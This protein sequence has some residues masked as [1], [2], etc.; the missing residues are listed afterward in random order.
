MLLWN[1]IIAKT[2]IKKG[3][4]KVRQKE[5]KDRQPYEERR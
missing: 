2:Y 4:K 3:T 5:K 1:G